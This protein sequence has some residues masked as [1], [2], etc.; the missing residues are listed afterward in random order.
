MPNWRRA[1]QVA[2]RSKL[3]AVIGGQS[4]SQNPSC[5]RIER[6]KPGAWPDATRWRASWLR[7][8]K[9]K[10][11]PTIS[12]GT[13]VEHGDQ[14]GP[15]HRRSGPELGHV[16]LPEEVGVRCFQ[17]APVLSA[18]DAETPAAEEQAIRSRMTRNTRLRFTL[19]AAHI[20][21]PPPARGDSREAGLSPQTSMMRGSCRRSARELRGCGR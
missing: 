6:Q 3:S 1:S 11:Q 9:L 16:G 4:Q 20:L 19:Q 2:R 15:T 8:R 7:Q 12:A 18:G 21:Q 17:R 5:K 13:A 14:I 10:S